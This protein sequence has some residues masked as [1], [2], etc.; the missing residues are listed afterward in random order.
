MVYRLTCKGHSLFRHGL[1]CNPR[2]INIP[3]ELTL[4][5]FNPLSPSYIVSLLALAL[6]FASLL[7]DLTPVQV[8]FAIKFLATLITRVD[9]QNTSSEPYSLTAVL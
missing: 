8:S 5:V 3:S 7:S 9:S 6:Q 2:T 1:L 4:L